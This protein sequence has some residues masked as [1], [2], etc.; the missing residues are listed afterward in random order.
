MEKLKT[1]IVDDESLAR[2]GLRLRLASHKD[3]EIVGECGNGREALAA[4][5]DLVPDLIFLDIQMPGVDGFDVVR[6]LQGDDM[7]MVVFV[8]AYDQFAIKAF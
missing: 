3:V 5:P 1:L 8:T 4:I 7:P 6:G 2:R